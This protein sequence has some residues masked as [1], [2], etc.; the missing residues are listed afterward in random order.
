MPRTTIA[1]ACRK[2]GINR[3]DWD[4]AKRQGVDCWNVE[5]FETWQSRRRSRIKPGTKTTTP[6][7]VTAQTLDEIEKAI[8]SAG[9]I[10]DV[11]ILKEKVMALKGIITVQI[12][13]KELVPSG[14]VREAA[15]ACYSV[16]RAELLKLTSDLPP[17]LS[18]LSET[19]IQKVLRENIIEI[20][21]NLSD[22]QGKVFQSE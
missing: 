6:E 19:K 4:E 8:R 9:N 7:A 14:K 18:G 13:S 17:Q 21:D 10:D 12:E 3:K 20:L 16:V 22:A 15:T 5:A 11:K 1:D 2:R